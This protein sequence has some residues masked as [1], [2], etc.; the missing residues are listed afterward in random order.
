VGG[1]FPNIK[2]RG[3]DICYLS[4]EWKVNG[5]G[6]TLG[7][8]GGKGAKKFS[9]GKGKNPGETAGFPKARVNSRD[10]SALDYQKL[11]ELLRRGDGSARGEVALKRKQRSNE[12]FKG[13]ARRCPWGTVDILDDEG[14]GEMGKGKSFWLRKGK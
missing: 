6:A 10:I 14:K 7:G 13:K 2:G 3:G 1:S 9:R 4:T 8:M 12:L 5:I 11:S